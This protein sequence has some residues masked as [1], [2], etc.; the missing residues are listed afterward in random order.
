MVFDKLLE[1]DNALG[2]DELFS[3]LYLINKSLKVL[4]TSFHLTIPRY[5]PSF[6]KDEK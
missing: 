1:I 4:P 2:L 5:P 3:R 6:A